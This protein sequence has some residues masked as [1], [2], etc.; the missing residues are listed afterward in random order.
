MYTHTGQKTSLWFKGTGDSRRL[1]GSVG[2]ASDFGL[3]HDLTGCGFEPHVGVCADSSEPGA[4]FQFRV[5]SSPCPSHAH[6][7]SIINKT[8]KKLKKKDIGVSGTTRKKTSKSNMSKVNNL[9]SKFILYIYLKK[10]NTGNK[11]A[12]KETILPGNGFR[13]ASM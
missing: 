11:W 10:K 4:C 1:G 13:T 9:I 2:G 6:A 8:L 7:L 5:C 12:Q 3:G